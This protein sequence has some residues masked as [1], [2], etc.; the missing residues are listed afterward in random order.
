MPPH[1]VPADPAADA[2]VLARSLA[3]PSVFAE[4]YDRHAAAVRSY[5]VRRLGTD[6]A[7][8]LTSTTFL[9]AFDQRHRFD[10]A[11]GAVRP[12]LFGIATT[13]A[14]RHR[15][16]EARGFR[17]LARA[18]A[19]TVDALDHADTAI[20]GVDAAALLRGVNAVLTALPQGQRDV[21][22]LSAW[23]GLDHGEIAQALSVRAGTVKSRLSRARAA[24]R[25]ELAIRTPVPTEEP[26]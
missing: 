10:P 24:L 7:D 13:L 8:D 6:L 2:A 20:A 17:L 11:R 1:A 18:G 5:L 4:L 9:V 12:W 21:L 14:K 19:Q 16:D 3:D 23:A 26:A 25:R 22:L 15:R